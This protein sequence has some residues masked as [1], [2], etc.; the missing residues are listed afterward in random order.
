MEERRSNTIGLQLFCRLEAEIG[1]ICYTTIHPKRSCIR[2]YG[3]YCV[4][5]QNMNKIPREIPYS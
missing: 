5:F 3:T 2:D 1:Y 4:P